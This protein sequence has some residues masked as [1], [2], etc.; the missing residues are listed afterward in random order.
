MAVISGI[1]GA[2]TGKQAADAQSDAARDAANV[3]REIYYQS[4]ED[5]QPFRDGGV[6]ALGA[7]QFETGLVPQPDGYSGF[8]ATP[9]YQ[10][11]VN[12]GARAIQSGAAA[13]GGLNSGATMK[14]LTRFGQDIAGEEY[15][16]YLNRLGA[17]SGTGQVATNSMNAAGQNYAAGAG[18]ALMAGGAAR[19]SGY[20]AIGQGI[21]QG[22]QGAGQIAGFG[23]GQG[24]FG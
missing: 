22:L 16:N 12:E 18:N 14:A 23:Y 10:F 4:R 21:Q 7:L 11:R 24:W 15:G 8:R 20:N 17:M 6:N 13:R 1:V 3:Q 9:G 5:L 2:V 19:A